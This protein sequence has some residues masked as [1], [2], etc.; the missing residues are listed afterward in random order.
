MLR[1]WPSI[2]GVGGEAP[3]WQKRQGV[4]GEVPSC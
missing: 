3:R 4:G 1:C 2:G